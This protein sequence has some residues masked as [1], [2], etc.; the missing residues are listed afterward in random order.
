MEKLEGPART[1]RQCREDT[2]NASGALDPLDFFVGAR[3]GIDEALDDRRGAAL[4]R[5][6]DI[7]DALPLALTRP[8]RIERD[9]TRDA[10]DPWPHR[11]TRLRL[12]LERPPKRFAR[13]VF[14]I[15]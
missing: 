6:A 7:D 1:L 4:F 12:R 2:A 11:T 13:A 8:Q 3:T 5:R 14:D 9:V 10:E 15:G